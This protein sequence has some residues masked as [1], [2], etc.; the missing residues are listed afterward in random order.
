MR[1]NQHVVDALVVLFLLDDV[2]NPVVQLHYILLVQRFLLIKFALGLQDLELE[3][4]DLIRLLRLLLDQHLII[5]QLALLRNAS[6]QL[7]S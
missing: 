3:G 2:R 6:F 4:S 1:H 5:S 7:V